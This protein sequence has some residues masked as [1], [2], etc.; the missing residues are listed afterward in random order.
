MTLL[1]CFQVALRDCHACKTVPVITNHY[2]TRAG[3]NWSEPCKREKHRG[4]GD[5]LARL[6]YKAT[7]K[8]ACSAC[9]KRRDTL[10]K[11]WSFSLLLLCLCGCV[12]RSVHTEKGDRILHNLALEVAQEFPAN[13]RFQNIARQAGAHCEEKAGFDFGGIVVQI[14]A[15]IPGGM[16]GLIAMLL[17][18]LGVASPG[19]S[20]RRKKQEPPRPPPTQDKPL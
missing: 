19:I 16:P 2:K 18:G 5:F 20:M 10:N 11:W 9:Q 4:I 14:L 15:A 7:K 8:P 17:G 12:A 6:I 3:D 13:P 1:Q